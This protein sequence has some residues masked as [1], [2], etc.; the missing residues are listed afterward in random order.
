[1]EIKAHYPLIFAAAQRFLGK[2]MS[3]NPGYEAKS[4]QGLSN[5]HFFSEEADDIAHHHSYNGYNFGRLNNTGY[6][7]FDF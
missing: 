7:G 5:V 4:K 3:S 2:Q 6:G 1:M